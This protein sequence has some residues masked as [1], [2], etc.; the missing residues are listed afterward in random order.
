MYKIL[1][2][3]IV[4]VST[5]IVAFVLS[6]GE[7]MEGISPL[8]VAFAAS[9]SAELSPFGIIGAAIGYFFSPG[10]DIIPL[11][12]IATLISFAVIRGALKDGNK[13]LSAK[14]T[15]ILSAFCCAITGLTVL[16]STRFTT[17]GCLIYLFEA[18]LAGGAS[19]FFNVAFSITDWHR[20]IHAYSTRESTA[21]IVT[22]ALLLMSL[23]KVEIY[24]INLSLILCTFL[25]LIV[26]TFGEKY[27]GCFIGS[28][29]AMVLTLSTG[30]WYLLVSIVLAAGLASV[31]ASLGTV[32]A[33]AAYILA[34]VIT[35]PVTDEYG[36]N[37]IYA[38][39]SLVGALLFTVLP[40]NIY[41]SIDAIFGNADSSEIQNETEAVVCKKLSDVGN[42]IGDIS[43]LLS[44]VVSTTENMY[45]EDVTTAQMRAVV[46]KQISDTSD[47]LLK[48]SK[49]IDSEYYIDTYTRGK[50]MHILDEHGIKADYVIC[51]VDASQRM[52]I[53]IR[54]PSPIQNTDAIS[55]TGEINEACERVFELPVTSDIGENIM[56]IKFVERPSFT[57]NIGA[58]QITSRKAKR[59]G[60]YYSSFMTDDGKFVMVLSDGMGTGTAAA[61][62]SAMS[63]KVLTGLLR[64]GLDFTCALSLANSAVMV[65]SG[66]EALATV[67]IACIDTY[68][69]KADFYK[70]GA[71]ATLVRHGRRVSKLDRVALPIGILKD[72]EFSH[73]TANLS[74]GDIVLMSSDGIWIGDEL[75]IAKQLSY[76]RGNSMDELA[77]RIATGAYDD[78]D[79][80]DDITVIA[81]RLE[82]R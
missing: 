58:H 6:F 42:A 12:Y 16:F 81:A 25:I 47:L 30:N 13:I 43:N 29:L 71:A 9:L 41:E 82:S 59:C 17:S 19:Y 70:A 5:L 45:P 72:V 21:L 61:L 10:T 26:C 65:N 75:R 36:I 78:E 62:G 56:S 48:L 31:F 37:I 50:V 1:E 79:I 38:V 23:S 57:I 3:S 28:I 80:S 22:A 63:V 66:D 51:I 49:Q 34:C 14:N 67:D 18:F 53:E 15:A 76:Y 52:F 8:G 33:T 74:K 7:V 2:K 20:G 77:E 46:T 73:A 68:T 55:L 44:R 54:C 32:P 35:I 24:H 60:D 69:G 39:H 11:R 27:S 4:R 40:E 64:E